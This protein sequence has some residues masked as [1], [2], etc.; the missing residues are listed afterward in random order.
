MPDSTD[1]T[2]ASPRRST[3]PFPNRFVRFVALNTATH[4]TYACAPYL[5]QRL[6][7][8]AALPPGAS[9]P[10][11]TANRCSPVTL[12]LEGA[13]GEVTNVF[14]RCSRLMGGL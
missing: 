8:F 10:I 4:T 14:S 9:Q 6:S 3:V 7:K 12:L 5:L 1:V 13:D 11:H 2:F